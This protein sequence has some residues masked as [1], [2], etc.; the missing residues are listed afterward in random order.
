MFTIHQ[1]LCWVFPVCWDIW[2]FQELS[3]DRWE[4]YSVEIVKNLPKMPGLVQTAGRPMSESTLALEWPRL[5]SAHHSAL[6]D[7]QRHTSQHKHPLSKASSSW[8]E[9]SIFYTR[10]QHFMFINLSKMLS[11]TSHPLFSAVGE[12][13]SLVPLLYSHTPGE[14][15]FLPLKWWFLIFLPSTSE[16]YQPEHVSVF[17]S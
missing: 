14:Q 1:A 11:N 8:G 4:N 6:T 9:F 16:E 7:S 13:S 17:N 2:S 12:F 5:V 3:K 10:T 15:R